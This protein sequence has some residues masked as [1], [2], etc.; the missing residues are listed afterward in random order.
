MGIFVNL[1]QGAD[2]PRGARRYLSD[3]FNREALLRLKVDN[4]E[5]LVSNTFVLHSRQL[6]FFYAFDKINLI[7]YHTTRSNTVFKLKMMKV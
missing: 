5:V 6:F 7:S 4:Q 1:L 2:L 3:T